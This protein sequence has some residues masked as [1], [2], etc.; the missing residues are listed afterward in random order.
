[1]K[2]LPKIGVIAAGYAA[3]VLIAIAAVSVRVADTSG[4]AA[5]A[6]SGMY[7]AGDTMLFLGV[8]GVL[9][10][11]PTGAALFF[12]RPYRPFWVGLSRVALGVAVTGLAAVILFAVGRRAAPSPFATWAGLSV[13]RL[14]AAP[15]LALTFVVCAALSPHRPPRLMF[16]AAT[17]MEAAV[18]IYMGVVWFLP[19]VLHRP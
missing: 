17:A 19:M 7:A 14:L 15:I 11:A 16:L 2:T 4:P 8:F 18:C 5:R 9:A 6:S 3:A 1:M 10:L 13:L 12:L